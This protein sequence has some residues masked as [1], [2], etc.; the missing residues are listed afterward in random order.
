[1]DFSTLIARAREA[2][3][4]ERTSDLAEQGDDDTQFRLG[5]MCRDGEGVEQDPVAAVT[6]FRKAAEQGSPM[7]Q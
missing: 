4:D 2:G 7:A 3:L 5:E 6:W 1:M